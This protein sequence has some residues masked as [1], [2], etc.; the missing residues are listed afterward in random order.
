MTFLPPKAGLVDELQGRRMVNV[1]SVRSG[2]S[3]APHAGPVAGDVLGGIGSTNKW[4]RVPSSFYGLS[5]VRARAPSFRSHNRSKGSHDSD[6]SRREN[7]RHGLAEFFKQQAGMTEA[8]RLK[9]MNDLLEAGVDPNQLVRV[10]WQPFR[11]TALFE[12]AVNG[13]EQ[14]TSAVCVWCLCVFVLLFWWCCCCCCCGR[15]CCCCC[16][17]CC[18]AADALSTW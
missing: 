2:S 6:Y 18:V 13:E 12:A 5:S 4:E 3:R 17:G 15:C 11:T 14:V 8:G 7:Q 1:F 9:A 10:A 16:C